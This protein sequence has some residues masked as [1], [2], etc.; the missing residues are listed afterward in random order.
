MGFSVLS[1]NKF[2]EFKLHLFLNYSFFFFFF[3]DFTVINTK[4]YDR[5][6]PPVEDSF[7]LFTWFYLV[8][9]CRY[10]KNWVYNVFL[11]S[12]FSLIFSP[13]DIRKIELI[14]SF[15]CL[16]PTDRYRILQIW[17]V[18]RRYCFFSC[19]YKRI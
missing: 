11:L 9:S 1:E 15:F 3:R 5:I 2:Y 19:R 10:K 16:S 12:Y 14:M 8:I 17:H 7:S 4:V 13:V 18:I 6:L